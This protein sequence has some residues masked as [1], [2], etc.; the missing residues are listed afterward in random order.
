MKINNARVKFK[1]NIN[2]VMED[3]EADYGDVDSTNI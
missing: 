1:L 3:I 2:G